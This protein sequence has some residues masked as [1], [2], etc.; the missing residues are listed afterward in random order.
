MG[1]LE[2]TQHVVDLLLCH[3]SP[4][5]L[6]ALSVSETPGVDTVGRVSSHTPLTVAPKVAVVVC[7]LS[8]ILLHVLYG[9]LQR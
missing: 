9:H 7:I 4:I 8:E 1:H 6:V 3:V 5:L 2:V